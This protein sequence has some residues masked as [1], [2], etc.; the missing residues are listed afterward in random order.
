VNPDESDQVSDILVHE[1]FHVT[2]AERN[3]PTEVPGLMFCLPPCFSAKKGED[4]DS[5]IG[6][7]TF[8]PRR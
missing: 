7:R 4:R 2:V 3:L 5:L 8:S 6:G 1:A